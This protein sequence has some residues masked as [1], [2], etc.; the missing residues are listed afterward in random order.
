MTPIAT[1]AT[2]VFADTE[3]MPAPVPFAQMLHN[4]AGQLLDHE[5]N[6]PAPGTG[7]APADL[8]KEMSGL[9]FGGK[10]QQYLDHE[11]NVPEP[12]TGP[13]P[14]R[15][16]VPAKVKDADNSGMQDGNAPQDGKALQDNVQKDGM[17]AVKDGDNQKAG[18]PLDHNGNTPEPGTGPAPGN[19][20]APGS[21][22]APDGGQPAA[23]Q[24]Q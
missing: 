1:T 14:G 6:V 2:G 18:A 9:S 5:G 23:E 13:A 19:G 10:T 22:K 12:G 17:P 16:P 24:G 3:E 7:P 20:P 8:Q 4:A 21:G 11:G 15:G